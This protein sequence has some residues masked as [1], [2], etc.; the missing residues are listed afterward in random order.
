MKK[1]MVQPVSDSQC[2][3]TCPMEKEKRV[4]E[5]TDLIEQWASSIP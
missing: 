1:N 4:E 3:Q 5:T 2:S